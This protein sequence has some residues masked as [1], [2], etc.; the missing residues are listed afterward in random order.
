MTR[1]RPFYVYLNIFKEAGHADAHPAFF[2]YKSVY[3][4]VRE[5]RGLI[6]ASLPSLSPPGLSYG[7]LVAAAALTHHIDA[8]DKRLD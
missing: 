7:Y 4:F 1:I 8:R 5:V 3:G 6:A 2:T